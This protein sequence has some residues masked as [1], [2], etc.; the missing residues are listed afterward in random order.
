MRFSMTESAG[1]HWPRTGDSSSPDDAGLAAKV[2]AGKHASHFTTAGGRSRPD[3]CNYNLTLLP[4]SLRLTTSARRRID[5]VI[6]ANRLRS[7]RRPDDWEPQSGLAFEH[8]NT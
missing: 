2:E 4:R 1:Q 3:A 5:I 7:V 6:R 8:G